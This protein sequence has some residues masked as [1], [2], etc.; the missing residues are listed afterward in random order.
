MVPDESTQ[1]YRSISS[2]PYGKQRAHGNNYA[3]RNNNGKEFYSYNRD[4]VL[5]TISYNYWKFSQYYDSVKAK[6]II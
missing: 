1:S 3:C 5:N 2:S 6:Y 4:G